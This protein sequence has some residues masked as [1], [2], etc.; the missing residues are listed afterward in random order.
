[1]AELVRVSL[2]FEGKQAANHSI[3]FYDVAEALAGFQ[4]SVA[5]TSHLVLNGEII[6]QA[7][8]LLGARIF[9]EPP[10]AGSWKAVAVIVGTLATGVYE[11][12]TASKET[13]LGNMIASLYDY[14][15]KE[16]LGFHVDYSKT[17]GQQYEE[18]KKSRTR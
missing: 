17:L 1:M 10:E 5:L 14:V 18:F 8:S 7:P 2:V 16:A 12:G 9:A 15:V 3:D 4:R 11:A 6:T 13:P